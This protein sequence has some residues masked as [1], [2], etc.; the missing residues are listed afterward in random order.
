MHDVLSATENGEPILRTRSSGYGG[1]GYSVPTEVIDGKPRNVPG[2]TAITNNARQPGIEQWNV[3]QTA[4]FAVTHVDAILN[5]S[6]VEGY[7]FLRYRHK[8]EPKLDG[9]PDLRN[10]HGYVLNDAQNL[11]TWGHDY[12]EADIQ[13]E[14]TPQITERWQEEIA[15][16]WDI[17]KFSHDITPI[18]VEQT[19]Y[20]P[21]GYAGTLDFILEI[22]GVS[23]LLDG[24][25]SRAIYPAHRMQV[26]CI[27]AAPVWLRR[28][29]EG[30][31]GASKYERKDKPDT[32][33]V[34]DVLPSF[35]RHG[36]LNFRPSDDDGTPA[37]CELKP[38]FKTKAGNLPNEEQERA[39]VDL[40]YDWFRGY[41]TGKHAERNVELLERQIDKEA[42]NE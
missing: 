15:E 39:I 29:P 21:L 24:K 8:R 5:R 23:W 28:V 38:Y 33:W 27:S 37:F 34:E 18:L 3:D 19:V 26:A 35:T 22:D 6:E 41:L 13:G 10:W 36:F 16:Q 2:I 11:G 1:H 31:E 14:F 9:D 30:T 12:V 4:A 7:G 25:S 42:K 20:N 40:H 32:W 17:F